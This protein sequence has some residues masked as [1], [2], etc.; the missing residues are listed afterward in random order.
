[1]GN[2]S[3]TRRG[4]IEAALG[5]GTLLVSAPSVAL[6]DGLYAA[7]PGKTIDPH[8]V[9]MVGSRTLSSISSS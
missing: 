1:M 2:I 7:A 5:V 8:S 6:A 9:S 3:I 4:F